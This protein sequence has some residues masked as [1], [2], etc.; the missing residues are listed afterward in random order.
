MNYCTF[1]GKNK[2]CCVVFILQFIQYKLS[3]SC[4]Y[5]FLFSFSL[6]RNLFCV[7]FHIIGIEMKDILVFTDVLIVVVVVFTCGDVIAWTTVDA[8]SD[9]E[10]I[11]CES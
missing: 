2:S 6:C 8:G 10:S 11:L 5:Y 1:P 9:T 4:L 3:E 7:H